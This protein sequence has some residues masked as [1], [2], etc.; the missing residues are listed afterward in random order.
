MKEMVIFFYYIPLVIHILYMPIFDALWIIDSGTFCCKL[1]STYFP[2]LSFIDYSVLF[3]GARFINLQVSTL[4]DK[5][6][7]ESQK[8]TEAVFSLV[9]FQKTYVAPLSVKIF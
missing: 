4:V 9:S 2:S 5:W 1:P 7:G 6:Y 3:S 8:R